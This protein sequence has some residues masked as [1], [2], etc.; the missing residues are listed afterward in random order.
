MAKL[1]THEVHKITKQQDGDEVTGSIDPIKA[2]KVHGLSKEQIGLG[3]ECFL[4]ESCGSTIDITKHRPQALAVF[5]KAVGAHVRLLKR[6]PSGSLQLL[7]ERI[8]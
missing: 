4:I 6:L 8:R 2:A 3:S 5:H 1:S 7:Q